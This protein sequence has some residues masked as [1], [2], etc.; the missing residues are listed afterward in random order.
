M[1]KSR[2]TK[3]KNVDIRLARKRKSTFDVPEVQDG[4]KEQKRRERNE[5]SE[6]IGESFGKGER[7]KERER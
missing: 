6:Q 3:K 7:E 1:E 2:L 5:K 4:E